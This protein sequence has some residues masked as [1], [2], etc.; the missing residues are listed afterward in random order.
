MATS[1]IEHVNLDYLR[2]YI[3]KSTINTSPLSQTSD[4]ASA[5]SVESPSS[6]YRAAAVLRDRQSSNSR[7]LA[8]MY[9]IP[10]KI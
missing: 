8:E 4:Y 6:R 5:S 3:H 2:Y 1:D 7:K 9:D 10:V